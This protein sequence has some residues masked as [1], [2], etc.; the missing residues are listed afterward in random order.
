MMRDQ[1]EAFCALVIDDLSL[2]QELRAADCTADGF[3]PLVLDAA[4]RRGFTL[5]AETVR[6]LM[7]ERALGI[8]TLAANNV[9]ETRLPADGWL[10]IRA[11]W[12]NGEPYLHWAYFGTRR[13]K[14]PFFEDDVYSCLFQP[15]NRLFRY[16]TSIEKTAAWLDG[17]PHLKPS[18]LIFHMS[19][20]GSTLVSQM[21]AALPSNI[22]VSEANPIDTVLQA[23]YW[24]PDAGEDRQARWL[25]A[26]VGALGQKRCG[27]EQRYFLKLDCWHTLALPLFRRAFPAVPW[28]F[29]YRDPVEVMVS[30]VRMPG[31]QMLPQRIGPNLYGIERSYGPGAE[32]DYYARVLGKVCEPVLRHYG[33]GG[34][35]L[36]NYRELPQA[37]F[38][39]ILPHFG[40]A[41]GEADRA[42]MAEAA[43][44]DAKTPGMA[45]AADSEAKQHKASETVRAAA[46]R[47]LDDPYRQL[48]ALRMGMA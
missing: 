29:L 15:F 37:L 36:V 31:T 13:L 12:A 19:R 45:F 10:P 34:G 24:R 47:W 39:A 44:F 6:K 20:C 22:V 27:D 41:C 30:Q 8:E 9:Q 26:A 18:G 5:S 25:A 40:V 17:R 23:P 3:V 46:A 28:V 42:A 4:R 14:R 16:V 21:L 32:E 7:A 43:R 11:S 38:T 2:Q 1:L 35:L 33:D 48:E